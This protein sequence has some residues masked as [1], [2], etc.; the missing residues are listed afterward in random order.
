MPEHLDEF[1]G[2]VFKLL[3]AHTGR[4]D[5]VGLERARNQ[6]LVRR[7]Q[8]RERAWRRLEDAALDLFAFDRVRP[9]AELAERIGAVSAQQVRAVFEHMLAAGPAVGLAGKVPRGQRGAAFAH[10]LALL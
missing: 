6:I 4:I 8:A 1:F 2:A 10:R 7:L 9:R 5:R 3:A